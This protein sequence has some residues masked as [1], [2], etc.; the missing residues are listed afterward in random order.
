M[1]PSGYWL[2]FV[3][4]ARCN[5]SLGVGTRATRS[6]SNGRL[7][8]CKTF[9]KK[10]FAVWKLK[11]LLATKHMPWSNFPKNVTRDIGGNDG[12]GGYSGWRRRRIVLLSID[13]VEWHGKILFYYQLPPKLTILSMGRLDGVIVLLRTALYKLSW[14]SGIYCK[15]ALNASLLLYGYGWLLCISD[16]HGLYINQTERG[17]TE[18]K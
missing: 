10:R 13:G 17:M 18:N 6:S 11:T 4:T 14:L 12:E 9:P 7:I 5:N 16:K 15:L 1:L 3:A 2:A 8:K